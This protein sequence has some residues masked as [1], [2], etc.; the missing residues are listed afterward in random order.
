MGF[1]L[2]GDG[3]MELSRGYM[4]I[5]GGVSIEDVLPLFLYLT[6]GSGLTQT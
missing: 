6:S 2:G 5:S 4:N 1:P 3:W